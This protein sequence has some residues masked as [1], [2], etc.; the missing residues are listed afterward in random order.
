[1]YC[2]NCN[3]NNYNRHNGSS[4]SN[5]F[6]NANAVALHPPHI[7][8]YVHFWHFPFKFSLYS[9]NVINNLFFSKI[10]SHDFALILSANIGI[11]EQAPTFPLKSMYIISSPASHPA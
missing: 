8:L 7:I 3:I 6:F 11:Y 2:K 4:S 1:M 5:D 9:F 10:S